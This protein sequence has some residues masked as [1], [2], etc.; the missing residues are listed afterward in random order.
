MINCKEIYTREFNNIKR[1]IEILNSSDY[2]KKGLGIISFYENKEDIYIKQIMSDC[3]KLELSYVNTVISNVNILYQ[4]INTL[5]I[6]EQDENIK[7]IIIQSPF[8]LKY[9]KELNKI[10]ENFNSI[11][12]LDS[13]K[14]NTPVIDATIE[15]LKY[16]LNNNFNKIE[17]EKIVI[18][19]R[20]KNLTIPLINRL[21]IETNCSIICCNSYTKDLKNLIKQAKVIITA[22]G[23][24]ELIKADWVNKEQI[25]IDI[26]ISSNQNKVSGDCE[27]DV[28]NIVGKST[29]VPGG[30]GLITR[31][32]L[33]NNYIKNYYKTRG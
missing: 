28:Y 33:F 16:F 18:L 24:A 2:I 12:I 30:I 17:G 27:K 11:K 3:D 26:G 31:I 21:I 7:G 19:G 9:K 32:C 4:F 6:Y 10:L 5:M 25:I 29:P 8:P 22:T 1:D 15:M 20:S 23:K 13:P 14:I